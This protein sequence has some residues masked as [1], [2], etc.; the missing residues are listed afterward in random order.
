MF[1]VE[2]LHQKGTGV[3][4]GGF[5][6]EILNSDSKTYGGSGRG[7]MGGVES[8]PI[9]FHSKTCSVNITLPPLSVVFLKPE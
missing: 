3:T 9:P 2:H 5:W 6:K 1:L 7:N 4:H 8:T